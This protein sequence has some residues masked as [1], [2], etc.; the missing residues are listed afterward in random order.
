[1]CVYC[2][3][4]LVGS[5]V[6]VDINGCLSGDRGCDYVMRA[7]RLSKLVAM[8]SWLDEISSCSW[9]GPVVRFVSDVASINCH[10]LAVGVACGS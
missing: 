10:L 9:V 7:A 5:G 6:D 4:S 1:M 3:S 8:S 2:F